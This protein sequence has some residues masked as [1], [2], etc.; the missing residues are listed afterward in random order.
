MEPAVLANS[1]ISTGFAQKSPRSLSTGLEEA[2]LKIIP[3][4]IKHGPYDTM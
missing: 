3:L 2:V 1:R 4:T